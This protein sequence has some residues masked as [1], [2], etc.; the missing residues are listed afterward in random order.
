MEEVIPPLIELG[1]ELLGVIAEVCAHLPDTEPR[2]HAPIAEDNWT[3]PDSSEFAKVLGSLSTAA[4][5]GPASPDAGGAS[6]PAESRSGRLLPWQSA[7]ESPLW[8]RELDG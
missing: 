8:D 2:H 6:R 3:C 5:D 7:S 4:N 1:F